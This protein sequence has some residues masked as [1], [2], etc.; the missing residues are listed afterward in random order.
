M[1]AK[2]DIVK[3]DELAI[4]N[5][6][7]DGK[8]PRI[9][10]FDIETSP[11]TG[12]YFER[13]REGNILTTTQ[14]WYMLCFAYK[15]LGEKQV[16]AVSPKHFNVKK[17]DDWEVIEKLWLLFNEADYVIAH[18]GDQFDVKKAHARFAIH[19]L[20]PPSPFIS[21]DTKK[22]AKKYFA[23]ESNKLDELGRQLGL[24]RKEKT[25][26]FDLW[27]ECMQ[28]NKAAWERMIKYNKKDVILLEQVYLK[29]RGWH[30]SHPNISFLSRKQGAC[31]NC[32]SEKYKRDGLR[33]TRGGASV[34]YECLDCG[35][36]YTGPIIHNDKVRTY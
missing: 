15:W 8:R 5:L 16:Q 13:W 26:G 1:P 28:G 31:P 32:Q 2:P 10:L 20:P 35:R 24:G 6:N 18:N 27:L 14:D 11:S 21:I 33:Y 19:G 29:L 25:G 12:M 9:L 17:P 23:F 4:A 34:R 36:H 7:P 30:S 3:L 22:I